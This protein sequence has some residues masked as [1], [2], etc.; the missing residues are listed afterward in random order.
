[1]LQVVTDNGTSN[2]PE[3]LAVPAESNEKLNPNRTKEQTNGLA[4]DQVIAELHWVVSF[5]FSIIVPINKE[6]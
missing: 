5:F 6:M 1:M 3:K 2:A 4:V